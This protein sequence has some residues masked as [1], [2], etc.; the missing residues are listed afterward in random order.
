MDRKELN[1][2]I[3]MHKQI[4]DF[5]LQVLLTLERD[6]PDVLCGEDNIMSKFGFFFDDLVINYYNT[7]ESDSISI[8]AEFLLSFDVDA[9]CEHIANFK[10]EL[11]QMIDE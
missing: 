1:T 5:C 9:A 3:A 2:F 8:P 10:R 4:N 7:K 11:D 6:Y